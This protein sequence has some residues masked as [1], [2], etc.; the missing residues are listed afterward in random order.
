MIQEQ[1][2]PVARRRLASGVWSHTVETNFETSVP[3]ESWTLDVRLLREKMSEFMRTMSYAEHERYTANP[4]EWIDHYFGEGTFKGMTTWQREGGGYGPY[5]EKRHLPMSAIIERQRRDDAVDALA[6][7]ME[8][9][10]RN[11]KMALNPYFISGTA[12]NITTSTSGTSGSMWFD[13]SR[14]VKDEMK[15]LTEKMVTETLHG[16]KVKR[17]PTYKWKPRHVISNIPFKVRAGKSLLETLQA[18]FNAWAGEQMR[19]C[20]G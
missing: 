2:D 17:E 19:V 18:D 8:Q 11:T 9:Q 6:Y 16:K 15:R 7:A 1:V 14:F 4:G 10:K 12:T 5:R 3:I 20:R 13:N